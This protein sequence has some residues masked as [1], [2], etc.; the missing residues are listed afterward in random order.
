METEES[1]LRVHF[2]NLVKVDADVDTTSPHP[3]D[4]Y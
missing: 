2:L 3:H 4:E 1:F